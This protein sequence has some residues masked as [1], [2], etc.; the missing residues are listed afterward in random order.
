[1]CCSLEKG[2]GGSES[3]VQNTTTQMSSQQINQS[4]GLNNEV[5]SY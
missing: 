2:I 4:R 5:L 1:M 3:I